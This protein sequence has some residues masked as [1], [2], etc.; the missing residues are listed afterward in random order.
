M[1]RCKKE[2]LYKKIEIIL[3]NLT[4]SD[5][6]YNCVGVACAPNYIEFTEKQIHPLIC[7]K[8]GYSVSRT[9]TKIVLQ[10]YKNKN[11]KKFFKKVLTNQ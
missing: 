7:K 8:L 6:F 11:G 4:W 10:K 5:I 3:D 9:Y 2:Q 1:T